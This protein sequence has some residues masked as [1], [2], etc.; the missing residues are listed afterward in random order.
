MLPPLKKRHVPNLCIPRVCGDSPETLFVNQIE[1]KDIVVDANFITLWNPDVQ[2]Q[3]AAFALLNSTWAKLML[4]IIGTVMGGGALKIE[5]SH[6]RKMVFPHLNID[7]QRE[8][9]G[10]GKTI[11]K[12]GEIDNNIQEQIDRI[13]I[14][15]YGTTKSNFL[16]IQLRELLTKKRYERTGRKYDE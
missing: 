3:V 11:L 9:V 16:N 10:I 12:R 4:E 8:L 1:E 15:P 13:V 7:K 6:I 14:S 5:A 2:S